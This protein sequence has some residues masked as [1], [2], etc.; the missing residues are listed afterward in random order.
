MGLVPVKFGLTYRIPLP[1]A[2]I[3]TW[4]M[5]PMIVKGMQNQRPT[6][7]TLSVMGEHWWNLSLAGD[8]HQF[9]RRQS[10]GGEGH[11][12]ILEHQGRL[13]AHQH[14]DSKN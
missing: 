7:P 1:D 12:H 5:R 14:V 10:S 6:S 8:C 11:I 3:S 9:H 4:E 2:I 13:L